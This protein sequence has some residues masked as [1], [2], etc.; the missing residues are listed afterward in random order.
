MIFNVFSGN[1]GEFLI[2]PHGRAPSPEAIA[3]HG[4]LVAWGPIESDDHPAPALW[5][6]VAEEIERHTYATLQKALGRQ[7][8]GL[9]TKT[10]RAMPT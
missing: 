1:S 5:H 2:T 8:L 9:D 4:P 6:R 10:H 3:S 7:L